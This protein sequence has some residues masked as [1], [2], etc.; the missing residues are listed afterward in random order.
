M[1]KKQYSRREFLKRGV[2]LTGGSVALGAASSAS[3]AGSNAIVVENQLA[4]SPQ[5]E[6][7]L[8][9]T[10]Q[11]SGFGLTDPI[12]GQQPSVTNFIEGFA[13]NISVNHGQTINFKINTDAKSYRIDIYRLGYYQGLG[14]RKIT[15]IQ[16]SAASV[17]P[18]PST[19]PTLGLVDAGN[20]QISASWAVP[21]T[22]VS[23]VYIA[24]LVRQDSVVGANHIPFVVRDD[25]TRHD[26]VF[27]TSDTTWHAYNG[28][29]GPNLYGGAPLNNDDRAY[30]VSYNRP[31]ATRD[32]VGIAAGPQDFVFSVE[33]AAI[34]WLEANGYDVCY[35]AGVDSDRN[36]AELRNHSI[37][38]S[39]GHDEY[40]SGAQRANVE[41]ARAAGVNLVFMSGNEVFWKTRWEPSTD[42]SATPYRTLVCYKE[43]RDNKPIDPNDPSTW[44]GSWRD[45][46]F[47][48]PADGGRPENALSGTIFQVDS[49]RADSIQIPYPMTQLRFWRNTSVGAT[50]PGQTAS[51]VQNYLGYEWDESP[52]NGFR[53]VGLIH[54]SSTTLQVGTYLL[55]YGNNTGT[56][57]AT[58]NLALY[59]D[60]SSGALVFGAGTVFWAWGLDA[61]H[62]TGQDNTTPTDPNVQQATVNLFADMGV[63]PQT[64]QSGLV[65]ATK[66]TDSTPP[67]STINQPG[68]V[69][70]GQITAITG[71]ATDSGGGV[72][73]GVEVSTDGGATWHPTTG[74]TSWTYNW[75]P[76]SPG[77]FNILS[78]AVD[79]SLNLE[80]PGP[81]IS[82]TVIPGA[83]LSLFNPAATS[84]YGGANAPALVGPVHDN[85][86][87]ELGV[88]FQTAAAGAVTGIRFYKNPWNT[89]SHVGNLW[90]ATGTLLA[91][92]TF[93]NETASGWQQGNLSSPVTLTP[94][95]TYIVSYHSA[96]GNYSAD[97][98]YFATPRTSGALKAPANGG[99]S[100]YAYGASSAFPANSGG[101]TNYWVDVIFARAGGAG[102][103]PPTA[104]NVSGLVATMNNPLSIPASTL[105]ANDTDP[106]GYT[107]SV[108]GVSN[109]VNGTVS[110]DASSQTVT[111]VPTSGYPSPN[112]T[113]SASFNYSISNGNGGTAT[114]L[115]SLTVTV[116][117]SSLFS[118]TSTPKVVTV[119]D[120]SG[121]ELGVKFQATSAGKVIGV[122]FYKGSQN[123]GT[124]VGNLWSSSGAL[125]ATVTFTNETASGW[126]QATFS[127]P[128][129]LTTGATYIVSYHTNG[130]YS[131]DSN[132]FASA[133][134]NGPLTAPSSATSGGNGVYAYGSSSIFPTSN[135][136]ATNYWVDVAFAVAGALGNQPPTANN[137][138]GFTTPENTALQIPASAL[139]ANDTDP[140]GYAL[141]ITGVSN[142]SN[143]TVTYDS[144]SQAVTVV[145]AN[146]YMG[147]ASFTYSITNGHGGT[148]SANVS[149]TVI[150]PVTSLFSASSSP[151]NVT[152]NDSSS[153]ELGVKFQTS[154]SGSIVGIRFYK[155]PQNTGTHIGN[156]W[157][158]TG[159][160]LAT[161]TFTNE[162]A[163]G[164]QAVYFSSPVAIAVGTTYVASYHTKGFYSADGNYFANALTSGPLTALASGASGG[165]GVYAYGSSS[166]FPASSYNSA[167][168]WV[169]VM[170][171]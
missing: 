158:A 31:I 145:P 165:N 164:W 30:K 60:R 54:L 1:D 133:L 167:N 91:S 87:V 154:S 136:N 46:R 78:R 13:D 20:W 131:A 27:Q 9:D 118:A 108:I 102:N 25:G 93:T 43:S 81:G 124:H 14:A 35:M 152:I 100:V 22:A 10:G 163:S 105:L 160:L 18:T 170:F 8:S 59:R 94:G 140:N 125:L 36:G 103:Q 4:G 117:T 39:V 107:L 104:N 112:Y 99:N 89:G 33:Y 144:G 53:P 142:P 51:L 159:A 73:A 90:S 157:S 137:D 166:N 50:R 98:N 66:S 70:Q 169:D 49:W 147:P 61:N 96:A 86:A 123:T 115:V 11:Y 129:A 132:Y 5:S 122:R 12:T 155:G 156:L 135:Y 21:A 47:S 44:T 109:P 143:C 42:P 63:Q 162:T 17:Q 79:D 16:K 114:G 62:D 119:N 161:A 29:G 69:M 127:N 130:F 19:V 23:G 77:T 128:V 139:L 92:A 71:T 64:L 28:W 74:T 45:P 171:S 15:T 101:L 7:D 138:S 126:Q 146:N 55:D 2:V 24:H 106:N 148:A 80:T 168:Y 48:P 67:V 120:S 134:T 38:L 75:W 97:A 32:G 72:V 83:T 34:R 52:D 6:W 88:Q 95:T 76:Q 141:S 149:L 150:G 65:L 56:Y 85:G 26:I 153:V 113:G 57:T 82:V 121:V 151:T 58:H 37:F 84:P 110:Y 40:W 111:F 68:N 41:A 116:P 3:A